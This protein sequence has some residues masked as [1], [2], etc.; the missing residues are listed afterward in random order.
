MSTS[1]QDGSLADALAQ[2][3]LRLLEEDPVPSPCSLSC[4]RIGTV[5]LHQDSP[6]IFS[7]HG[8]GLPEEVEETEPEESYEDDGEWIRREDG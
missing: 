3:A 7:F 2:Q 6:G 5:H 4:L 8:P 1:R